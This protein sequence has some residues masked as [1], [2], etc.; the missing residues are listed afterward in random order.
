MWTMS[1]KSWN[2][3]PANPQWAQGYLPVGLQLLVFSEHCRSQTTRGPEGSGSCQP[4]CPW[5][6][7]YW[8]MWIDYCLPGLL[9]AFVSRRIGLVGGDWAAVLRGLWWAALWLRP[10]WRY[11]WVM[12]P[13]PANSHSPIEST[14]L[15]SMGKG[16]PWLVGFST[17][18]S[19]FSADTNWVSHNLTQL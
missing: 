19:Q 15:E 18:I 7:N 9:L 17:S 2:R 6:P 5:Q 12:G 14:V 8:A 3:G 4:L 11:C 13:E 1:Y 10:T 16:K